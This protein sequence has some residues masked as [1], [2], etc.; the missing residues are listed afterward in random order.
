[1]TGTVG[2]PDAPTAAAPIVWRPTWPFGPADD[3]VADLPG[4]GW[5]RLMSIEDPDGH[6]RWQWIIGGGAPAD[7]GSAEARDTAERDL[8]RRLAVAGAI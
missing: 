1:M 2:S 8:R 4:S 3:F 5:T 6:R 7:S